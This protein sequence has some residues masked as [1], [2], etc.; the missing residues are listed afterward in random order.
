MAGSLWWSWIVV[1][2]ASLSG[3]IKNSLTRLCGMRRAAPPAGLCA[4][5]QRSIIGLQSAEPRGAKQAGE[6]HQQGDAAPEQR[7]IMEEQRGI[8]EEQPWIT[9][10]WHIRSLVFPPC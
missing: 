4:G 3:V 8:I 9:D 5:Y 10:C 1:V 7:G 6:Q 2:E